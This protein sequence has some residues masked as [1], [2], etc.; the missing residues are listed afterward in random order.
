MDN[1]TKTQRRKTDQP[2]QIVD[3]PECA[4]TIL[5]TALTASPKQTNGTLVGHDTYHPELLQ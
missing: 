2:F 3:T 4:E 5:N 1:K